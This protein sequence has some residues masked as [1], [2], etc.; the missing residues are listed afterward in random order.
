MNRSALKFLF[1]P[2]FVIFLLLSSCSEEEVIPEE[3][4]IQVYVDLMIV[5]DTTRVNSMPLDSLK[6][7]VFTKH[8]IT[9]ELYDKTVAE[10]NS[11]PENWEEFFDKAIAYLEVLKTRD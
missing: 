3:K 4:F 2:I 5:Q 8:N 9:S 10:Y 6:E 1:Q 11:S 7:I